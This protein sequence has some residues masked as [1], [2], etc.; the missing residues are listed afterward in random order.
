M[1]V[2]VGG[3]LTAFTVRTKLVDAF[4][5]PSLTAMVMVDVPLSPAAGVTTTVRSAPVPPPKTMLAIGTSVAFDDVADSVN[6]LG[7][8]SASPIVNAIGSVGVFSFVD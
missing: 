1:A 3:A 8:V 7:G 6:P 2:M 5:A 4:S